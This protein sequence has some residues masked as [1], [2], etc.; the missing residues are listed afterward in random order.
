MSIDIWHFGKKKNENAVKFHS[1][2]LFTLENK[3]RRS[4]YT[5]LHYLAP[6]RCDKLDK[7]IISKHYKGKG[8]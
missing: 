8:K 1:E 2:Y 6:F 7:Q 4:V 3:Q 5:C